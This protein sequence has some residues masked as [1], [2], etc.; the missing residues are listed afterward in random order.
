MLDWMIWKIVPDA[1]NILYR[2][3][4]T[5]YAKKIFNS[6]FIIF[7]SFIL[8]TSLYTIL[9]FIIVFNNIYIDFLI[10]CILSIYLCTKNQ[11]LQIMVEYFEPQLYEITKY[12]VNNYSNDK[13]MKWKNIIV[14]STLFMCYVYFY[15]VEINSSLIRFYLL[16]YLVCYI[17]LDVYENTGSSI[18]KGIVNYIETQE[19]T[20][21]LIKKTFV[22][23]FI[24]KAINYEK[25]DD[26]VIIDKSIYENDITG[27]VDINKI[28]R[29]IPYTVSLE[30]EKIIH[31]SMSEDFVTIDSP[32]TK[33]PDKRVKRDKRVAF[34]ECAAR[35]ATHEYPSGSDCVA[36][37]ALTWPKATHTH[38]HTDIKKNNSDFELIG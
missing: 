24:K 8:R 1:N 29:K 7:L 17:Y 10:Q 22:F 5:T 26:C 19:K 2:I 11:N 12:I 18:R 35:S 9:S 37:A 21:S 14:I 36:F 33:D 6:I 15:L 34:G 28:D 32:I 20:N 27:F 38:V 13:Y 31:V 3:C 30:F 23:D 25:D 16:E 4:K